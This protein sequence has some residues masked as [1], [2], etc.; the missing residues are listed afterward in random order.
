ML[1]H[2]FPNCKHRCLDELKADREGTAAGPCECRKKGGRGARL[3]AFFFIVIAL[4][5]TWA[6]NR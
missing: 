3:I 6:L 1:E 5:I 4:L 2:P